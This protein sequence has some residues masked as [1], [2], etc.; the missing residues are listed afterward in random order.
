MCVL[1]FVTVG[2][3]AMYQE[4]IR[5][6]V[7]I[8]FVIG[9]HGL[10]GIV[11]PETVFNHHGGA[12]IPLF[13]AGVHGAFILGLS[14][15]LMISWSHAARRALIDPLTGLANRTLFSQRLEKALRNR[16]DRYPVA[17]LFIDLDDF[18][19]VN[20]S[21]GHAAGDDLLASVADRLVTSL[22]PGD[23]VARLGGDEFAVLLPS[24]ERDDALG[25]ARRLIASLDTPFVINDT[26]VYQHATIGIALS[27]DGADDAETIVRDADMAM[28]DAKAEGKGRATIF[29]PELHAENVKR[30]EF[31][32]QLRRAIESE[33]LRLQYQPIFDL[34]SGRVSGY[35]ALVRWEHP[36]RGILPPL[37]FI[38]L[39]EETGLIIPLGR[40]VL[41]QA[42][43]QF[44]RWQ[45]EE[46]WPAGIG[47]TVNVSARELRSSGFPGDVARVLHETRLPGERLT[48]ELTESVLVADADVVTER[49][50]SLKKLGVRIAIDDFGSGYSSLSYLQ[51][52]P[53]DMLKIDRTFVST[54]NQGAAGSAVMQAAL[55]IGRTLEIATVAEGVERPE[56]LARLKLMGCRLAQGYHFAPPLGPDAAA[57]L[58]L[59]TARGPRAVPREDRSEVGPTPVGARDSGR[60]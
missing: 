21:L 41:R 7:A 44:R 6:L 47:L 12:E 9:H 52:L 33:Q 42:C 32:G 56:Q 57:A 23:T 30:L 25:V 58:V 18:K 43:R 50:L 37:E 26:E 29:R 27:G 53:V 35:E 36:V 31:E 60:G 11:A 24:T 3:M 55:A 5:L 39:A 20:D 49:M 54:L 15:V 16:H 14:A 4:W 17:V 38:P 45:Q 1:Y 34:A 22:R 51:R 13:W 28:Y 48:L 40:W 8:A 10:M 59:G 46:G 19:H 2:L